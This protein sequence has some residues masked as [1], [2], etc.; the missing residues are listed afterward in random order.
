MSD[1]HVYMIAA[2]DGSLYTGITKD[3]QRRFA[4]HAGGRGARYFRGRQP[5]CYAYL[6]SG[7]DRSS[8]SRREARIKAMS[9]E[10]KEGLIAAQ[11]DCRHL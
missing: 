4:E 7:H 10:Q 9:R 3:P 6:E 1:W 2:S 5:L 8:A 11:R